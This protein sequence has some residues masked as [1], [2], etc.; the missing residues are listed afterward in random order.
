MLADHTE[1]QVEAEK[2]DDYDRTMLSK[3]LY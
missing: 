3:N 2:F 1:G